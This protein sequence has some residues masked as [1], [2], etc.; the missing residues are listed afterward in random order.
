MAV[1]LDRDKSATFRRRDVSQS[2][3]LARAEEN[4]ASTMIKKGKKPKASLYEWGFKTRHTPSDNAVEDGLDVQDAEFL[5]NE[6][7]KAMLQGRIQKGRVAIGVSDIAEELADEHM[8]GDSMLA[9]NRADAIVLCRENLEVTIL[10]NGDSQPNSAG[11]PHKLRGLANWIRSANPGGSPDLPVPAS[12]LT[13]AGNILTGKAT[14]SLVTEDEFR[15][16]MQSIATTC[17]QKGIWDVFVSPAM[18]AVITNWQR[19]G[20]VTATTAPLRRFTAAQGS[21]TIQFSVRFYESD[22]G[23]LRFHTHF[24]LPAGVHAL[25]VDMSSLSLRPVRPPNI[26]ELE[27]RGGGRKEIMEYIY[28]LEVTNPQ[29]H[30]KITT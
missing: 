1:L 14:A 21:D 10:K 28:G 17:R 11:N 27:Y 12:A 5:N 23:K 18:A 13:P 22:F 2:F 29:S 3:T 24:S 26:K 7:N 8:V 19:T 25:V 4:P 20:D 9:D 6:A 30:G 15:A 16:I